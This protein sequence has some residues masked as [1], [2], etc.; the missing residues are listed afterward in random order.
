MVS[1]RELSEERP[2]MRA[3]VDPV[4]KAGGVDDVG[5]NAGGKGVSGDK[6]SQLLSWRRFMK[7][8]TLFFYAW[9]RKQHGIF[10]VR[11]KNFHNRFG[12]ARE[13]E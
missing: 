8:S 10:S 7:N 13:N 2:H 1:A 11:R 3:L 12:S 6:P 4:A 9:R 5:G